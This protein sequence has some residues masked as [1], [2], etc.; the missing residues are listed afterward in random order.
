MRYAVRCC[1][2]SLCLVGLLGSPAIGASH[3]VNRRV[4]GVVSQTNLAHV[5]SA[6]AVMGA[7][8]YSCDALDTDQGGALRVQVGSGQVYLSSGSTAALEDDGSEI[9]VVASS[10]TVGFSQPASGGLAIRTPAGIVRAASGGAAA[11]EVVF[12][13]PKELVIT[14][15]RGDL[16]LDN[17]GE[18]RTIPEGK[19]AD[20]TFDNNLAQGCH[21]ETA[22]DQQ[23]Q[24]HPYARHQ[25]AFYVIAGAAVAIPGAVLWH[26]LTESDS[27]PPK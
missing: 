11:G 12:K 27:K 4:L 6:N 13:G 24:Q 26:D 1:L 10:G 14:S 17:G 5:D 21:N 22:A 20:V 9:Q 8:I 18:I 7:D 15:M 16:L 23:Q 25:I 19:S 3:T 2:V